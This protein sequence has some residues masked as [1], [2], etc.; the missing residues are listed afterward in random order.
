MGSLNIIFFSILSY[1]IFC[2]LAGGGDMTPYRLLDISNNI[3]EYNVVMFQES[4]NF[5]L[6]HKRLFGTSNLLKK[7]LN[8]AGFKYII[9]DEAPSWGQDS[10]LLIASRYEITNIKYIRYKSWNG[11]ELWTWKGVLSGKINGITFIN[12]HLQAGDTEANG[13]QLI[14]LK[15]FINNNFISI[16]NIVIGGDFNNNYFIYFEKKRLYNTLKNINCQD[17]FIGNPKSSTKYDTKERLDYLF[18]CN[19]NN[20]TDITNNFVELQ[21]SDHVGIDTTFNFHQ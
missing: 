12:T 18:L 17:L 5:C 15:N 14:E 19:T 3:G 16:D 1:N 6:F 8:I 10:G 9:E 21:I 11:R 13:N 7:Y 4:F 20:I 2:P